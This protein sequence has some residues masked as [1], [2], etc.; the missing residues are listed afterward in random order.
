[1]LRKAAD[2]LPNGQGALAVDAKC[3]WQPLGVVN[4]EA[5]ALA[6][7]AGLD[8]VMDRCVRSVKI[9]HARLSA[10]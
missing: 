6:R 5:D 3:L 9:E 4:K 8:S 1:M 10:A 2:V 7:A